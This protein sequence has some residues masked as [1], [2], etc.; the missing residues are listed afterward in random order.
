MIKRRYPSMRMCAWV[1]A[2][3]GRC[4]HRVIAGSE[5][6]DMQPT[7][8]IIPVKTYQPSTWDHSKLTLKTGDGVFH[9]TKRIFRCN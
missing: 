6:L 9:T 3:G 1:R 4:I 8:P 5:L 7:A 2:V